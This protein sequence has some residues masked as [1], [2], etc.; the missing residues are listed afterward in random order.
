MLWE[1][2][3]HQKTAVKNNSLFVR[4]DAAD[5]EPVFLLPLGENLE[6][7]V[8]ILKDYTKALNVPLCFLG[9]EGPVLKSFREHFGNEFNFTPSRD[10][11][12]YIY[13]AHD[14]KTLE[15]KRF[16]S[17]RN[18]ISAFNKKYSWSYEPLMEANLNEV[19]E[20]ADL[21]AESFTDSPN[22]ASVLSENKAMKS[23]LPHM[24][25]LGISG[26]VI[27]LEGKVIA[28]CFGAKINDFCFDVQVEKALPEY[29][30]VYSVIN[31]EFA[32][33]LDPEIKYI[34]R[35]DD[36]GLEGLRKAKLSYH[37]EI[38]LQKYYISPKNRSCNEKLRKT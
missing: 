12:E 13:S 34:N 32:R 27:R 16:H 7:N 4:F 8:N 20:M 29:R 1:P 24:E 11:F 19:F 14:L 33:R 23:V 18:H 3:Y 5:K 25:I 6:E 30:T 37:P 26:G 38:L 10:D 28:F 17:K 9:A 31:N 36:L 2:F 22:Y 15:G 35:E 21:W